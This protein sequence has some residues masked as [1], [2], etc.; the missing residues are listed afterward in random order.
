MSEAQFDGMTVNER[1]FSAGLLEA[2]DAA[3]QRR[4]RDAMITIL[5][6]VAVADA[7]SIADSILAAPEPRR[8][9]PPDRT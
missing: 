5:G 7:E 6:Q 9:S 1:L 3:T 2:F 8:R 4:N